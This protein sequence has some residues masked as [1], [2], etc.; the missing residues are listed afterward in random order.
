MILDVSAQPLGGGAKRSTIVLLHEVT[1]QRARLRELSNFAGMVAHDLRG[2]LTVLDGWLEVVQ[3]GGA[4]SQELL[5]RRRGGEGP[6]RQQAD[7]AGDRGLAELHRR[8]ERAAASRRREA[9]SGRHRDR[10]EPS[11]TAGPDGESPSS[12]ST[13]THSVQADPGLLRQLLDNLV[14]NAIKYTARRRGA[15]GADHLGP[16]TP[17]PAGSRVEVTDHGVGIPE[18]QEELIFEEFHRG[19]VRRA[20]LPAP[21]SAWRSPGGSS[22]CTAAS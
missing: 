19:P 6:R 17:S 4:R 11:G 5:V 3:D 22:P 16:T 9:G 13:S 2:P 8:P 18:G 20:A 7:A 10:G 1:A 21:V 15:V 14:G 12:S